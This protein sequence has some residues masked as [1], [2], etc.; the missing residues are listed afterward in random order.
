MR[1]SLGLSRVNLLRD[2]E[3]LEGGMNATLAAENVNYDMQVSFLA[4]GLAQDK[5]IGVTSCL[6]YRTSL[7]TKRTYAGMC[8]PWQAWLG[9]K[10][11]R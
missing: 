9:R 10:G 4:L 11:S 1:F 7:R 5:S 8:I 3:D 2:G 6:E